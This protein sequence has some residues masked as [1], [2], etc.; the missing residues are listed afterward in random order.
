MQSV[1]NKVGFSLNDK[2]VHQLTNF[3]QLQ[4]AAGDGCVS[5]L[6]ASRHDTATATATARSLVQNNL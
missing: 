2:C 6:M 1:I 3:C 5:G 4:P